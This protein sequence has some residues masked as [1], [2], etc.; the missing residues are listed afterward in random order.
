MDG[1]E[2]GSTVSYGADSGTYRAAHDFTN[3]TD[4]STTL[5]VALE[6]VAEAEG[7]RLSQ[8][9]YAAVDPDG[10]ARLFQPNIRTPRRDGKVIFSVGGL[11]VTVHAAGDI[12][13]APPD[14]G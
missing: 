9:L 3:R 13:I 11:D 14:E 8:S 12:V 2:S 6:E 4:A 1:D 10:L 5:S 7:V